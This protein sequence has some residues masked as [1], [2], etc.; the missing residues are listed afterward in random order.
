MASAM[1]ELHLATEQIDVEDVGELIVT[2][3]PPV[4]GQ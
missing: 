2:L 4:G 1:G 3:S